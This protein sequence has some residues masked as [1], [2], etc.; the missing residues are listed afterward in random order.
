[1]P[2][3]RAASNDCCRHFSLINS[4]FGLRNDVKI[5]NKVIVDKVFKDLFLVLT[6]TSLHFL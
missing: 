3:L 4:M 5:V 6:S 2:C 1:M